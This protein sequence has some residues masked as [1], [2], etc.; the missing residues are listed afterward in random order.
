MTEEDQLI[1]HGAEPPDFTL[2]DQ[3]GQD[4]TP[5]DLRGLAAAY[6]HDAGIRAVVDSLSDSAEAQALY[7]DS[8]VLLIEALYRQGFNRD[9]EPAGLA[10]WTDAVR[11]H[12]PWAAHNRQTRPI[13]SRWAL[14][15]HGT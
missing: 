2:P 1:E 7:G 5:S 6:D 3:D 4:V 13:H 8:P 10:Y 11:R 14:E 9:P 15:P 12:G